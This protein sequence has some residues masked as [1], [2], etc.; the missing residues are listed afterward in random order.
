LLATAPAL[1]GRLSATS[2]DWEVAGKNAKGYCNVDGS[3]TV[4]E[5]EQW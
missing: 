3:G 5:F 1:G 4:T 2:F